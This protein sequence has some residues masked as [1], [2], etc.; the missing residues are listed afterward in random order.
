MKIDLN[1]KKGF[2]WFLILFFS[3]FVFDFCQGSVLYLMPQSQT[4][5]QDDYLIIDVILNTEGEQINAGT[6]VFE[7]PDSLDFV[8]FNKGDSVFSLWIQEPELLEKTLSFVGGTPQGFVGEGRVLRIT[9]KAKELGKTKIDLQKDSKILLNDGKGTEA[10]SVFLEGNYMVVERPEGLIEISSRTHANQNEWYRNKTLHVHWDLKE[11]NL[12]SYLL[13]EDP[14]AM[15]DQIPDRPEGELL[16]LGD[17]RY[18]DLEDAIYYFHLIQAEEDEKGEMIWGPKATFRA[19]I[20]SQAPEKFFPKIAQSETVFE[21]KYFLSFSTT[22]GMS[23]IDRYEVLESENEKGDWKI[24]QT[25]YLLEDQTLSSIIRVRAFDKAGNETIA[26]I[27]PPKKP[28]A[29]PYYE[30]GTAI[31]VAVVIWWLF[32]ILK[33][34]EKKKEI[35]NS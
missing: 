19:M 33:S 30:I 24:A 20:D 1:N 7:V 25:P 17:M 11:E 2:F 14:L 29:F 28:K 32:R 15:P 26:E 3:F 18:P 4:V 27:L 31:L 34:R 16:W 5:Y 12:Y 13:T 8:N 21:G 23:G 10:G 9:F 22:D 35:K 6:I